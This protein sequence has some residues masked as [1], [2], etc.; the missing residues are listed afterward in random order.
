[1]GTASNAGFTSLLGEV[2]RFATLPA[3]TSLGQRASFPCDAPHRPAGLVIAIT[4]AA[5]HRWE[6]RLP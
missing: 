4:Y 6:S 3:P 5:N 1:M 2:R